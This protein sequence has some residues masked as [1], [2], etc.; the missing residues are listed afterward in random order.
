MWV[1]ACHWGNSCEGSVL[2]CEE[3]AA[4]ACAAAAD[5][6]A[7]DR[8]DCWRDDVGRRRAGERGEQD[9]EA[10]HLYPQDVDV[11]GW[12]GARGR[13]SGWCWPR[14]LATCADLSL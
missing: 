1:I 11:S 13:C 12:A 9:D 10:R 2:G 14:S 4:C 6:A 8:L 3:R 5:A 7:Q